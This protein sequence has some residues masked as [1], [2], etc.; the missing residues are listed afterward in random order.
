MESS[1]SR[2]PMFSVEEYDDWK[3]RMQ[4]HLAAMHDEMWS[5]IEEG[6][7]EITKV[8]TDV[9]VAQGAPQ[10]IPN[11]RSEWTIDEKKKANLDN[12]AR[13]VLYTTMDK[14]VFSKIKS[15][16][17]AKEIWDSLAIMCE[18]TD[19]IKE[20]KLTLAMQKFE[21]F[22]MKAGETVDKLDGR[23]TEIINELT[24]LGKEYS[25]REMALKI[26]RA[27]PKE[28]DMKVVAM[29]DAKDL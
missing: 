14:T 10:I 18:G 25:N 28:W 16:K 23:F 6:P 5:V 11:P 12:I 15:C 27:L 29:S 17:T 20:N 24:S 19:Q 7:P 3:I 22:K 21:S 4:A 13:N 1:I 2:I 9:A 26:L 8:N